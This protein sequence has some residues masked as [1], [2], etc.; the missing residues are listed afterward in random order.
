MSLNTSE[1]KPRGDGASLL[2]W[3]AVALVITFAARAIPSWYLLGRF[4]QDQLG[5]EAT[6][7]YGRFH[8]LVLLALGGCLALSAPRASGLRIGTLRRHWRGVLLVCGVPIALTALVYPNLS[9]RPFAGADWSMWAISP[10]AQDLVFMG[11][12]YGQFERVCPGKVHRRLPPNRALLLTA[13]FFALWHVPNL[14]SM[15]VGYVAF[16][17]AYTSTGLI[18]VGLSRQWTGSIL[19]G[20]LVHSA[21]NLIAWWAN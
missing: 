7:P 6:L 11:F 13:L 20:T 8:S 14:A 1:A 18:V 9:E 4:W 10:L 21:V 2:M 16:Q 5:G 15:S 17:L 12:L 3:L 19:Y